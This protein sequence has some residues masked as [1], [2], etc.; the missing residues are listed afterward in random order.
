MK[1]LLLTSTIILLFILTACQDSDNDDPTPNYAMINEEGEGYEGIPYH[2]NSMDNWDRTNNFGEFHVEKNEQ[3]EFD[4][5]GFKGVYEKQEFDLILL[6]D[7]NENNDFD[8]DTDT[9]NERNI[10][11]LCDS[12][13]E[14]D[15]VYDDHS[16]IYARNDHCVFY[17]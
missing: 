7:Q 16:F 12:V 4:F 2:C 11:F 13:D 6:I 1:H 3:C 9:R 15:Y 5:S 17:F 8:N 14:A 10:K